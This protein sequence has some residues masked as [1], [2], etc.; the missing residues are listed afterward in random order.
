MRSLIL[1]AFLHDVGKI[2]TS[3]NILL[4]P[5]KLD[6]EEFAVMRTHVNPGVQIIGASAWLLAAGQV[7]GCHHEKY[8]GGG[9]L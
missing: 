2:G 1:G 5:G 4:K 9:Y 3:D 6:D 7:I 8:S